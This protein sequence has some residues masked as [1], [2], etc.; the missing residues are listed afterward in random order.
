[1]RRALLVALERW[2]VEGKEPPASRYP[3][4]SDGTLVPPSGLVNGLTHLD[5]GP[6][7]DSRYNSGVI[8]QEPPVRKGN[9]V[10]LVPKVDADGNE[11]AGVRSVQLQA[12]KGTYTGW[13]LRRSGFAAGELCGLTGS[14]IPFPNERYKD[15]GTYLSAL[16]KA[17]DELVAAGFLLA[18]D[19]P[20]IIAAALP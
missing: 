12:P 15:R 6:H 1:M 10:V 14:F 17:A 3:K 5:F 2:V 19:A 13:N 11:I 8:T 9:Y 7:F 16:K 4:I 20:R 18:E